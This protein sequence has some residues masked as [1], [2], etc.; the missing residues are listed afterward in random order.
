MNELTVA[1]FWADDLYLAVEVE[2]VQEVLRSQRLT[3]VPLA[4]P[5]VRGLL[6]LRGQIVTAVDARCRLGLP[7][8][9]PGEAEVNFI[10]AGGS[11]PMSLVVDR[12][13]E[14]VDV[15]DVQFETPQTVE[16]AIRS[17][18]TG[19]YKLDG[20]LLLLVDVDQMLSIATA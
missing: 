10:I 17:L 9:G 20:T 2:R 16:A 18:V 14:I 15:G 13:G 7:Q 1:T 3:P 8:R 4:D 12:E 11:D 5:C 6:N 19:V